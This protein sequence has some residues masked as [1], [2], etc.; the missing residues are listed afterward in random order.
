MDVE[1]LDMI[2]MNEY[3]KRVTPF[4]VTSNVDIKQQIAAACVSAGYSMRTEIAR[5]MPDARLIDIE[6]GGRLGR[7]PIGNGEDKLLRFINVQF[8]WELPRY[9]WTEV[10]T[11]HFLERNSQSTMHRLINMNLDAVCSPFVTK[12]NKNTLRLLITAYN[13]PNLPEEE[14]LEMWLRIKANVP[15]GLMLT[16]RVSTNYATLKTI[17]QQRKNHRNIEWRVFCDWI[18]SLPDVK[19]LGVC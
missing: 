16:S 2:D 1:G 18:K 17:Y 19:S 8:D 3:I 6:R 13:L 11:Y 9:M 12:D 15:E 4:N 10:D 7:T 14:K 5:E